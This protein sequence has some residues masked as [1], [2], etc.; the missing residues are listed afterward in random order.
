MGGAYVV[1]GGAG[2]IGSHLVEGL[3]ARGDEVVVL[4]DLSTGQMA[5]LR[6]VQDHPRLRVVVGSVLDELMVDDLIHRCDGVVHLA[7][8]VGVKL[9][10]DKPLW[11]FTTNTVARR[12]SSAR[13]TGT[14]SG[15]WWRAPPRSTERTR[16]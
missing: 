2:F 16:Q 4:D 9:I 12:S 1:T 5:N 15:S 10:I 7:A 3:L 6:S 8:A 14:A 13:L 11:S